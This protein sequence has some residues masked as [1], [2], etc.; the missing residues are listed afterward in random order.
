M[1][2]TPPVFVKLYNGEIEIKFFPDSH[3]YW[4][5]G[6]RLSGVTSITGQVDKSRGLMAWQ[7]R[8]S[9]E[10]LEDYVGKKLTKAI[11]DEAVS[12]H[13]LKK[14]EACDI[15]SLVHDWIEKYVKVRLENGEKPEYPKDEKAMNGILAFLDWENNHKVEW[16]SS[17][18]IVYSKKYGY[19]GTF[20]AVAIVDGKKVLI[21]FK[22]SKTIYPEHHLQATGYL[23]AY[24]EEFN[25]FLDGLLLHF[26]KETGSFNSVE[27]EKDI[28]VFAGLVTL[29]EYLKKFPYTKE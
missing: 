27:V 11:I 18:Q 22:T 17:E 29:K 14:E 15:G 3:Q 23:I 19:V 26:D 9:R 16:L 8:L 4:K 12:Q 1:E 25:E 21:D 10:Y 24:Y 2:K 28:S 20:D 7:E 6:K 13:R 5:D